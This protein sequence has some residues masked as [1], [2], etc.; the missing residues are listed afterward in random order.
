MNR[1]LRRP[2]FRK[3]GSASNG[4]MTGVDRQPYQQAGLVER[5]RQAYPGIKELYTELAPRTSTPFGPGTGSGFLTGFGLNLLSQTPTGNIFSTAAT[6]ARDPFQRFQNAKSAEQAQ[7]ESINRAILGDVISGEYEKDIEAQKALAKNAEKQFAALA[8]D[9][10]Y[11]ALLEQSQKQEAALEEAIAT[12]DK[13]KIKESRDRLNI[14]KSRIFQIESPILKDLNIP[15]TVIEDEIEDIVS[16]SE[17][18]GKP[19]SRLDALNIVIR[20]IIEG[21]IGRTKSKDGGRIGYEVGG[22]VEKPMINQTS[23][24]VIAMDYTTLRAR[25]PKQIGDDIV[26]L[27]AESEQALSDFA[28]I[29]TQE[30]VDQFNQ[31]YRVNLV[32]PQEV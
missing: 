26:K 24:P 14:T 17:A 23:A 4:I 13:Q 12:G 25:L 31:T 10:R 8:Q 1:I 2:M 18:E 32:L 9:E 5:V 22:E 7:D 3:G 11:G 20:K 27:L 21:S 15:E 19:I 6:A 28:N 16:K 29:R 30:D